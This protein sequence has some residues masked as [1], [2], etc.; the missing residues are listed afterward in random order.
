MRIQRVRSMSSAHGSRL[1]CFMSSSVASDADRKS[2]RLNSS[3]LVIS[4]AVFC[5]NQNQQACFENRPPSVD[6]PDHYIL[7]ET[8]RECL[9]ESTDAVR[10]EAVLRGIEDGSIRAHTVDSIAPSVFAHKLLLAWDYSF[11]DDGER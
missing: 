9:D 8:I 6:L 7:S 5:L 1:R 3:H 10:M 2:T 4:Y 11:L